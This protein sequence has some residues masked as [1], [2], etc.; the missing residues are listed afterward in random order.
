MEKHGYDAGATDLLPQTHERQR[1]FD[2]RFVSASAT[3][4]EVFRLPV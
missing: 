2:F 3:G 1:M 4:V